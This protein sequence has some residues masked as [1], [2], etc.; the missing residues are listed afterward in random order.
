MTTRRIL[1]GMAAGAMLVS[2]AALSPAIGASKSPDAL[3]PRIS[4]GFGDGIGSFT[5]AAT[6]ARLA[7]SL[8]RSG[9]SSSGFRFTPASSVRLTRSVTVAV[10]ARSN[11]ESAASGQAGLV[12]STAPSIA[13]IAYNLGVAVG[14][15]K[16]AVSGDVQKM[17]IVGIGKRESADIGVS[18]TN[19]RF[20]TR[21]QVGADRS[22]GPALRAPGNGEGYS[23]DLGSSYSLTRGVDVTAGL[24]YRAE[25]EERLLP[26]ND[27]RRDSQAVYVGTAFRF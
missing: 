3:G 26:Q 25:R 11:A 27:T 18:Y 22:T 21:L 16:F 19:R 13:P 10:R 4:L 2:L 24:R 8:S 9:L 1:G 12:A 5:P 17:D 15:K 23:V 7:A 6:D 14:W 20:S